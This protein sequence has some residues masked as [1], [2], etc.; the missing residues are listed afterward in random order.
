M[1]GIATIAT[2]LWLLFSACAHDHELRPRDVSAMRNDGSTISPW[3]G[4]V[5]Y[6]PTQHDRANAPGGPR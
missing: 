2:V 4:P 5:S 1:R 6:D 3:P